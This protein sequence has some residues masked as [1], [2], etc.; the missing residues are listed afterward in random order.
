MTSFVNNCSEQYYVPLINNITPTAIRVFDCI[1]GNRL[2]L[3][4]LLVVLRYDVTVLVPRDSWWRHTVDS[5]VQLGN[6]TLQSHSSRGLQRKA[7][8]VCMDRE[9]E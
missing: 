3:G 6:I 7:I 8:Q 1:I 4:A 2:Q 5:T 9:N